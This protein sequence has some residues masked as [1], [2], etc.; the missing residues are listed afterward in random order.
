VKEE[1]LR[2][3]NEIINPIPVEEG[4]H[5]LLVMVCIEFSQN[6]L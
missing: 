5:E 4:V 3:D 2:E 1:M 6:S